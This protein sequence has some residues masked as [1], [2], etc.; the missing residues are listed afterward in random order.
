[1]VPPEEKKVLRILDLVRQQQTN[2]FKTLFPSIHVVPKKQIVSLRWE[3]TILKQPQ[4]VVV[5]PVNVTAD[6]QRGFQLEKDWLL[7]EDLS[8]LE[9]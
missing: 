3:A 6:L 2:S 4:Q 7:E 5:L 9:A 1:M 8:G